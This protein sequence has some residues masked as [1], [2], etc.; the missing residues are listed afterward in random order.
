M[1]ITF[2]RKKSSSDISGNNVIIYD[3]KHSDKYDNKYVNKYGVKF[4]N[5]YGNNNNF[6][7][8]NHH[9]RENNING[10]ITHSIKS[11]FFGGNSSNFN[12]KKENFDKPG[13]KKKVHFYS[14]RDVRVF[15]KKTRNVMDN[16]KEKAF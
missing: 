2:F 8:K 15:D 10:N 3:N 6:I 12:K 14:V 16:Y 5:K 11:P 9:N 7:E 13:K 4:G 1:I